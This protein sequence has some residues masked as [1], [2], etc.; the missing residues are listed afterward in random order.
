MGEKFE[1]EQERRDT[2]RLPDEVYDI[3]AWSLPLLWATAAKPLQALPSGLALEPVKPGGVPSGSVTGDGKVA[4]LLPWEGGASAKALANLLKQGVKT[5]V[6]AKP[7]IL[8]ARKFERGTVVIRRAGNSEDL[9]DRLM[10]VAVATGARFVGADTGYVDRGI[11]IGSTNVLPVKAPRI[12][13]AWDAPTS[14]PSDGDLR[15]AVERY[16]DYPVSVVRTSTLVRADLS[17]FDV[18][19]LPDSWERVGSYATVLGEGGV[20]RLASWVSEGGVLVAVGGGAAFLTGEKVGLLDSKLEKRLARSRR[21]RRTRTNAAGKAPSTTERDQ[22]GGEDPPLVPGS[23][24]RVN[25]D[26]DS[27]S[28]PGSRMAPWTFWS[29]RGG[30]SLRLSSTRVSTSAYSR[31]RR[32]LS[33]PAGCSRLLASNSAQGLHD[34]SG[35]RAR[36]VIAFADDGRTRPHARHDAAARQRGVLRPGVPGRI[37]P[38]RRYFVGSSDD[39]EWWWLV[40]GVVVVL[41]LA[42]TCWCSTAMPTARARA[43][44]PFGASWSVLASVSRFSSVSLAGPRRRSPTSRPHHREVTLGRQ[45]LRSRLSSRT[46]AWRTRTTTVCFSGGSLAR[47]SRGESSSLQGSL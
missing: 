3:T 40:F 15:Y 30:S 11:D 2:K 24:L 14:A 47:S 36:Q 45:S 4:F 8:Q 32:A 26:T 18:I 29:T 13:I 16:L 33:N 7:F 31:V 41:L 9:R 12:A 44:L 28:G 38:M 22:A 21:Q 37:G 10:A 25:L 34:G 35:E 5:A 23:I 1:K 46:S 42:L 43:R 19:I 20:K 27:S 6:A 17:H 39:R